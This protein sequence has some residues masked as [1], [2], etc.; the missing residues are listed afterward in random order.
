MHENDMR[1]Q[2]VSPDTV[3]VEPPADTPEIQRGNWSALSIDDPVVEYLA[4]NHWKGS[5]V[6]GPWEVARLSRA[7]YIYRESSTHWAAVAKFYIAKAGASAEKYA[8]QEFK[9]IQQAQAAG[10]GEGSIRSIHPMAGQ[11][12]GFRNRDPVNRVGT[13]RRNNPPVRPL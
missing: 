13:R 12:R 5:G 7:A 3:P 1:L 10:L 8:G 2:Q 6:S 9:R 4:A 11:S